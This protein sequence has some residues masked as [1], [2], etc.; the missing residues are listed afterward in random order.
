MWTECLDRSRVQLEDEDED[1]DNNL[2]QPVVMTSD[3]R[4]HV[5]G[6]RDYEVACG[7]LAAMRISVCR[8]FKEKYPDDTTSAGYY[9]D[10]YYESEADHANHILASFT[11]ASILIAAVGSFA[12]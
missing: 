5:K 11:T 3:E 12:F 4:A 2:L 8:A 7:D 10:C 6:G 9:K 1:E